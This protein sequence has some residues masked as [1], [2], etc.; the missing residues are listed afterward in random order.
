MIWIVDARTATKKERKKMKCIWRINYW[1]KET[2]ETKIFQEFYLLLKINEK[3]EVSIGKMF[4][5]R[6]IR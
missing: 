3:M 2:R 6:A 5:K 1:K 4:Y